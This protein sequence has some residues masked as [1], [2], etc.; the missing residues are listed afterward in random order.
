[1]CT[2]PDLQ[3]QPNVEDIRIS[4][5]SGSLTPERIE[6]GWQ[7]SYS[8]LRRRDENMVHDYREEID[9]L[10]V[11]VSAFFAEPFVR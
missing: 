3:E 9:T 5:K 10:L 1:M 7:E 2:V 4:R 8:E 11:F 6:E